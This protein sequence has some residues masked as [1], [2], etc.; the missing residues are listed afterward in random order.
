MSGT[1]TPHTRLSRKL[2]VACPVFG[3]AHSAAVVVA[4]CNCGGSGVQRIGGG[5]GDTGA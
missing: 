4:I 2:G 5:L 3:F 1:S